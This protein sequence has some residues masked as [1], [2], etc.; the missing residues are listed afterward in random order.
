[1]SY[2]CKFNN[3]LETRSGE[4]YTFGSHWWLAMMLDMTPRWIL[5]S[6]RQNCCQNPGMCPKYVPTSMSFLMLS[7]QQG[8]HSK[9]G[10]RTHC[11]TCSGFESGCPSSKAKSTCNPAAALSPPGR[12]QTGQCFLDEGSNPDR[13]LLLT[14]WQETTSNFH[15]EYTV[16]PK[17][18]AYH[19]ACPFT[20]LVCRWTS[21]TK[22]VS[23]RFAAR[24]SEKLLRNEHLYY[25]VGTKK[26]GWYCRDCIW[27]A[28]LLALASWF[29][30]SLTTLKPIFLQV[31]ESPL[32]KRRV[33]HLMNLIIPNHF[34]IAMCEA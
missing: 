7:W 2:E 30:T 34:C 4:K 10:W 16:Y 20:T 13:H 1:M 8:H 5:M 17:L 19:C 22:R 21:S 14:L 12:S 33:K 11:N 32:L 23:C 9:G 6:I 26:T 25:I 15:R 27:E 29:E 24:L 28:C 31:L 3:S 18:E